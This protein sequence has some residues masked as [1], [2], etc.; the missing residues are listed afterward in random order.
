ML[1]LP[2]QSDETRTGHRTTNMDSDLN[3]DTGQLA[4]ETKR[5]L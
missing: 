4:D 2:I 1:R 5:T 3:P